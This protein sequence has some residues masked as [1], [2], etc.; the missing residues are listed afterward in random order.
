MKESIT[1]E[2]EYGCGVACF[3]FIRNLS[4]KEAVVRLGREKTVAFG[5]KP[6]D[7]MHALNSDGMKYRNRYVRKSKQHEPYPEGT[8]ILIE[9]SSVYPVGHYLV[10]H[11]SL[12]MDPWINMPHDKIVARARSGFRKELPGRAMYAII[13][14]VVRAMTSDDA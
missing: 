8:V 10:R 11:Q 2:F 3:A 7:L 14:T 9:R 4:Y 6:N 5:W 13:P 1:Q 12:W